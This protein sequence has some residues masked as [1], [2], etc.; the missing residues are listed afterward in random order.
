MPNA[1]Q[2]SAPVSLATIGAWHL[3]APGWSS[4]RGQY[5]AAKLP[6]SRPQKLSAQC[7]TSLCACFACDHRC[8]AP[9]WSSGRGQYAAAKLP[10]SRP[11]KLSAQCATSLCACF[12]CDYR[13][14]APG[15]SLEGREMWHLAFAWLRWLCWRESEI[16]PESARFSVSPSVGGLFRVGLVACPDANRL[17]NL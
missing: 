8:L 17:Q 16:L 4:G 3:G 5:A 9:G 11:Q 10:Y 15:W 7:V 1:P 12:A 6:Y 13:C 14:L 2:V